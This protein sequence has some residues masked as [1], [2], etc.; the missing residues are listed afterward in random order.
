[1]H[2]VA[3]TSAG[4]RRPTGPFETPAGRRPRRDDGAEPGHDTPVRSRRAMASLDRTGADSRGRRRSRG[5]ET[6]LRSL[7][8]A[9]RTRAGR[10]RSHPTRTRPRCCIAYGPAQS[11]S[12]S[13]GRARMR[14]RRSGPPRPAI[15]GSLDGLSGLGGKG[16]ARPPPWRRLCR[17]GPGL[18][19]SRTKGN[20]RSTTSPK[21]WSIGRGRRSGSSASC[22]PSSGREPRATPSCMGPWEP[23]DPHGEALLPRFQ[24][25]RVGI[26]S[27]RRL[28]SRELSPADGGRRGPAPA[29]PAF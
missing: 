20:C 16:Y 7:S 23:E 10:R 22:G 28:G 18:P 14:N 15:R 4:L 25:I 2:P 19:S 11:R 27:G 6:P 24:E 1:M 29:D 26:G 3:D 17:S 21:R 12:R 9:R 8:S 13:D 5:C